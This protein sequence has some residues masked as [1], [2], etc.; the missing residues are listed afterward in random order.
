MVPNGLLN[1]YPVALSVPLPV[2]DPALIV[3]APTVSLNPPSA[4]TPAFI[5]K[6][7]VAGS[8]LFTPT[9]S[10]PPLIVVAP[11][12][13]LTPL[14]VTFPVL[15]AE[16]IFNAPVDDITPSTAKVNPLAASNSPVPVITI[17]REDCNSTEPLAN[18]VPPLNVTPL[19][20]APKLLS[21]LIDK[22]PD[23]SVVPPV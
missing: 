23:A 1:V 7:L 22:V 11:E 13:V 4:S 14:R 16:L 2:M 12:Y 3:T 15:T 9:A 10:V 21:A 20:L 19:A 8:A 18:N 17:P 6:A 5:V